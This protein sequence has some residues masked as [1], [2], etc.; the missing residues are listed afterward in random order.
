MS[1]F[2]PR[3]SAIIQADAAGKITIARRWRSSYLSIVG[4]NQGNLGD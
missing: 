1:G 3:P 4:R 2:S